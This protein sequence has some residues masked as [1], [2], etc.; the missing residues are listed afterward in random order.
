[1]RLF[2]RQ[3]KPASPTVEISEKSGV[4]YLHLG[5]PAIQ[6]AM[7]IRDPQ[8]LELE[9]TRAMMMFQ[10]LHTSPRDICLIGLGGGSIAKYVHRN[11][12]ESR[13]VVLEVLPE[14]IAAA[15]SYFLLPEDDAHLVVIAGDGAAYVHA[16]D[17]AWDVLLVDGYDAHRIV[18]DLASDSFYLA[19]KRALRAGGLAVFNLWGSDRSFD[20][21]LERV[22]SAFDG[23]VLL[24][25]AERKGNIQVF[26]F[27][28]AVGLPLA[29]LTM[30]ARDLDK[31]FDLGYSRFL[32][33]LRTCNE[34]VDD[35]FASVSRT[36]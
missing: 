18:E 5:G 25:P 19:C 26:A 34:V 31:Q 36:A 17:A 21:F 20:T 23:R 9:Y 10:V 27:R 15:R 1:M 24:L 6:S 12:A 28:D 30:R 16:A 11:L 33:R 2:G 22:E 14:V 13:L 29:S 3:R 35:V 8:A 7:R 4:R 32:D